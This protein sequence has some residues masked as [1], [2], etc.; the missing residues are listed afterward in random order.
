VQAL[1]DIGILNNTLF[2]F[3]IDHG[4]ETKITLFENGN[5]IA[6]F[7][8]YPDVIPPGTKYHTPVLT[9]DVAATLIDLA[10]VGDSL[11]DMDGIS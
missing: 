4:F 8:Q 2:L 5:R 7:I 11:Y 6:Q 1:T 9:I 3:L 10:G